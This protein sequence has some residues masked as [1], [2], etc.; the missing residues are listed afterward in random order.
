MDDKTK[1]VAGERM[2]SRGEDTLTGRAGKATSP[3]PASTDS[4]PWTPPSTD[5]RSR[6]T[7]RVVKREPGTDQQTANI[8]AEIEQ[9]REDM[10][11]TIDE[12]Q[13][14]LRP[15]TVAA[16]AAG[17]VRDTA[18]EAAANA[19]DAATE[20]W[21]E[22]A[23]SR[24]GQQVRSNPVPAVMI[25]IGLVGLGWLGLSG[26]RPQTP[27]SRSLRHRVGS[28]DRMT[29]DYSHQDEYDANAGSNIAGRA[30]ELASTSREYA[31]DITSKARQTTRRA[32]TQLQRAINEN[33]LF[34]GAAA[35]AA[36][37]MI[38]MALPSTESE[39]ELMGE[40]RD[41]L[42]EGAQDMAR[43]AA[44]KVQNAATE[45]ARRVQDVA[46]DAVGLI[47]HEDKS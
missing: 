35:L 45:A 18:A 24:L 27:A 2:T 47:N 14:R 9:T 38:G 28:G 12:I 7:V 31:R 20:K 36:G 4:T 23:G 32:Q 3:T 26:R 21:N 39:N 30:N 8:R 34:V 1:G 15:S 44:N 17:S 25:G 22:V 46:S 33:P 41:A 5:E 43:D 37:A 11:D 42:V 40:T 10:S 13:N 16:N 29:P 6:G 19:R